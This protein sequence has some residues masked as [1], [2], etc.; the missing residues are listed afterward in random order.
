MKTSTPLVCVCSGEKCEH[1]RKTSTPQDA[2]HVTCDVY[3]EAN[4]PVKRMTDTSKNISFVC[5][6]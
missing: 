1:F 2:G 6:W 4:P 3:L 5:D